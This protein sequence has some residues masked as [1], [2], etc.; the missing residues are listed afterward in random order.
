M[1][2][3]NLTTLAEKVES[4]SGPCRETDADIMV[5]RG[6]VYREGMRSI[7]LTYGKAWDQHP[8]K[9]WV[10]S[11]DVVPDHA[12]PAFTASLDAA[13]TLVPE[14]E[15]IGWQVSSSGIAGIW[16]VSTDPNDYGGNRFPAPI[17][18]VSGNAATPALALTAAS[19]R[20]HAAQKE[21]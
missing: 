7:G 15:G 10:R 19:L 21:G 14:G 20:A 9:E 13:M 2:D 8:Y 3:T 16:R 1:T 6:Y 17:W 12:V 4:L 5:A 18:S 11:D